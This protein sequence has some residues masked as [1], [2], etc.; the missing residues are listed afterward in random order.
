MET[1]P[2]PAPYRGYGLLTA[3]LACFKKYATFSGR[4]T[5]SEF[6]YFFLFQTLVL[7]L[8]GLA[9]ACIITQL[10]QLAMNDPA[11]IEAFNSLMELAKIDG[12]ESEAFA[13]ANN[14]FGDS[15][16]A[17]LPE[18]L[19]TIFGSLIIFH[20]AFVLFC[21]LPNL[22]VA[23]RRLHDKGMSGW[24]NLLHLVPCGSIILYILCMGDSHRGS[25]Q[26]GP[27]EKYPN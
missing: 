5:A 27:S 21:L 9:F 25:N 23:A 24:L 4:A 14:A 1:T 18:S 20:L 17:S 8:L 22:A 15:V 13:Q 10:A 6:W 26:Y 19:M 12:V 7:L 16:V 2:T 3:P 11:N